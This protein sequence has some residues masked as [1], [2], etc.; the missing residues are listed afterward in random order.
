MVGAKQD[1]GPKEQL[2]LFLKHEQRLQREIV[3]RG[4]GPWAL[5]MSTSGIRPMNLKHPMP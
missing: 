1:V 2:E 3:K 4:G 5:S